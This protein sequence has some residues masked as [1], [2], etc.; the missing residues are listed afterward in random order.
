M[1]D[2]FLGWHLYANSW[3]VS[4]WLASHKENTANAMAKCHK[5]MCETTRTI[6]DAWATTMITPSIWCTWARLVTLTK[7]RTARCNWALLDIESFLVCYRRHP[8]L[9]LR[10]VRVY[11]THPTLEYTLVWRCCQGQSFLNDKS[12]SRPFG[13][14]LSKP[15]VAIRKKL[16]YTSYHVYELFCKSGGLDGSRTRYEKVTIFSCLPWPSPRTSIFTYPR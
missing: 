13:Q 14:L 5:L 4:F 8:P 12:K 1:K 2:Q 3:V 16:S 9:I 15:S 6:S 7:E 11:E 10:S